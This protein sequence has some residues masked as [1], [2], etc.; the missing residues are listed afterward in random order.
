VRPLDDFMPTFDVREMH[1]LA[2][3]TPAGRVDRAVRAVVLAEIPV[4]RAL[5]RLRGVGRRVGGRRSVVDAM[6]ENGVLLEDVPGEGLVVGL[7][8]QFWKLRGGLP[9]DRPHTSEEFRSYARG[10]V[11]RAVMD[12]RVHPVGPE[13]AVLSTETRIRV[14]DPKARRKFLRYWFVVRPFSGLTR[15]LLLRAARAR[16]EAPA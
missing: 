8:G 16:A 4:A 6:L 13:R 10:D 1:S 15:I 12:V 7:T 9:A 14:P 11:A 3:A 2:V 5:L